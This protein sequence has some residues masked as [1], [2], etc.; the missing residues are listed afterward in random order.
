MTTLV[1]VSFYFLHQEL[2]LKTF[3]IKDTIGGNKKKTHKTR[4]PQKLS[5][6]TS[7]NEVQNK[8]TSNYERENGST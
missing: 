5:E 2:S 6:N 1:V 8:N 4:D 3:G 7:N